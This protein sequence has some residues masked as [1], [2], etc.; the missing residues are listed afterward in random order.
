[1]DVRILS[2][3]PEFF[4]G[5]LGTSVLGR[6]IDDRALSVTVHNPR[7]WATNRHRTVD[8]NPYGGGAGMLLR[9]TELAEAVQA[10]RD[11]ASGPLIY[12][13]PQ[14]EPFRQEHAAALA[15][16]PGFLLL[17][18]RYE[19]IDERFIERHVDVELSLG[20]FVLSGGEPAALCVVDAV[21]RLLPGAL[22]NAASVDEESFAGPL[23]EYPQFTR[24]PVFE[25]LTVPEI[26]LSGHHERIARWR[27]RLAWLR[28]RE[29]RPD[30]LAG[31][32]AEPVPD[33]ADDGEVPAW[34]TRPRRL[35]DWMDN[36][37]TSAGTAPGEAGDEEDG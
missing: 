16:L 6:A 23:L 10:I 11:A 3:F 21:A 31:A 35:R 15:T 37:G 26:L 24:P 28:T 4:D 33:A 17:C 32:P 34:L 25:G 27:R 14:G 36:H 29:R 8:D 19:G 22:G 1:M 12:L 20:D 18:G 7:D 9:A 5:P 13:S 2:L 30:L